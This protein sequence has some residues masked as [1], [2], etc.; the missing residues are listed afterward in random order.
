MSKRIDLLFANSKLLCFG[1]YVLTVP[2]DSRLAFGRDFPTLP[3]KAKDIEKVMA[4]A[5][6]KILS[7]NDTA[8]I[9]Y[10]GKG[11]APNVWL[12]R[13][14]DSVSAKELELEG[15]DTYFAV[16][17]H[18]FVSGGGTAES[19]KVTA[20]TILR[21][22][23]EIAKNLR[24]RQPDEVPTDQGLCHEYGFTRDSSFSSA[25]SQVGLHM[26]ALPDVVF[27]VESNQAA[28][29]EG[30]N[31]HGLLKRIADRKRE[32][33]SSYPKLTT[34]REGKKTVHG[35]A[36]EESLVRYPDGTQEFRWMFIGVSGNVAR[37][38]L[39]DVTMHTKVEA[40]RV[41][42]ATA[43]SLSDEEA[44]A[45]WDKLLEGLKFRVAVPGAPADA[46]AIK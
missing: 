34:L 11:P 5:Q 4:A 22:T 15:F 6:A 9:T 36:G 39:L 8:E 10:F 16:G 46:V 37:P 35:W 24:L 17:P 31:G 41:G 1:R 14:Y 13:S 40:D 25:L 12:I 43:S 44:I 33:G 30:S 23:V 29:T 18:I 32:V 42:A 45:L 2:V 28:S 19:K 20:E 26:A 7:A 27:S 3:N 38:A 21:R